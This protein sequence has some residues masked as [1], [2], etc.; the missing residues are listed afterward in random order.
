MRINLSAKGERMTVSLDDNN[1][2]RTFNL[3][4]ANI[5]VND[6]FMATVFDEQID[7]SWLRSF[8]I[9]NSA[10]SIIASLKKTVDNTY[11]ISLKELISGL[12][13]G[14]Q[15]YLY[16]IAVPLDPKKRMLVKVA[17]RIVCK[18]ALKN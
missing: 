13:P 8:T 16:T 12:Q 18:I 4:K 10:D 2:G 17:R 3:K 9:H 6:Y 15:Y 5:T 14:S 1:I 11:S 7:T